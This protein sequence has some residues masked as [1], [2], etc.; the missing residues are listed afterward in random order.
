MSSR[1]SMPMKS[2]KV[3]KQQ[4]K[5]MKAVAKATGM[6]V[7]KRPAAASAEELLLEAAVRLEESPTKTCTIEKAVFPL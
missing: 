3:M 1:L 5:I 6:K 7:K 4:E 2:M